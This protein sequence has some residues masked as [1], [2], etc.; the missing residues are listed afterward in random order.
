MITVYSKNYCPYCTRAK[1]LL[2]SL[3][4]KFELIDISNTPEKINELYEKSGAMT[5]PQIFVNNEFI[6]GFTD[7]D[8]LNN[9]GKL[10]S[11][12]KEGE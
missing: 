10:L 2:E 7:I 8:K 6:G 5:V 12:L 11:L 4:V 1:I 9:E 3:N